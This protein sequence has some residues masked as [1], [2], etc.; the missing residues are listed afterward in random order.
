MI[1]EAANMR[2]ILNKILHGNLMVFTK[3]ASVIRALR[4]LIVIVQKYKEAA[5]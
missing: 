5:A 3:C 4:A 2:H 1:E